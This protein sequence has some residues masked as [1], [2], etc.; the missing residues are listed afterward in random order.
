VSAIHFCFLRRN[1]ETR[2]ELNDVGT[3]RHRQE[4]DGLVRIHVN[5]G[6]EVVAFTG[7]EGE[8][9][10]WVKGH[11]VIPFTASYR[12]TSCHFIRCWI[13]DREN[14]F[15][16]DVYIHFLGDRIVLRH[17]RFTVEVERLNDIVCAD[18]H[19]GFRFASFVRNVEFVEWRSVGAAVRLGFGG[20]FLDYF[21]L[22]KVHH[23]NRVIA[24]VRRLCL[25]QFGD[26]LDA[27]GAWSLINPGNV[28]NLAPK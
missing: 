11:P 26:V 25:L 4:S 15:V 20:N 18:I 6:N 14:L 17:S 7:E 3:A 8:M 22:A 9:M 19:D 24:S 5:D 28:S 1:L 13:N 21:H 2:I 12:A 10:F 23:A 27:F 16:L